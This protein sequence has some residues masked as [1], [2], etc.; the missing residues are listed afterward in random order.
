M[1]STIQ[2]VLITLGKDLTQRDDWPKK[3]AM[4][5]AFES[6]DFVFSAHLMLAILGYTNELSMSLQ[7][8]DQDI[9]NAMTLVTLAKGRMQK[10]RNDGW[11]EFYEGTVLS[12]CTKHSIKVPLLDEK[13]VPHGRSPRFYLDQT[14]DDHFRR[15]VYIGVIDKI[16]QELN[17]RFDEVNMELLICMAALNPSNSF[18]SYDA[19]KVLKLAKFYPK[20]ISSM[21]I[22][23]Q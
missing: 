1:Y 11:E 5:G 15:E 7:K 23:R 22:I 6:F 4:V 20:D 3:H 2:D 18:A 16:S 17:N 10:L 14:N 12:F 21:D 8:R 19:Q 9:V 13:Y